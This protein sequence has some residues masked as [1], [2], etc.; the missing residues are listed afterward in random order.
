[1]GGS[2]SVDKRGAEDEAGDGGIMA[3]PGD[4]APGTEYRDPEAAV[5]GPAEAARREAAAAKA[6]EEDR[7]QQ[8]ERLVATIPPATSKRTERAFKRHDEDGD[9]I[10]NETGLLSILRSVG[11]TMNRMQVRELIAEDPYVE[12]NDAFTLEETLV[13]VARVNPEKKSSTTEL[14]EVF[15]RYDFDGDG[16]ISAR[17]L[18]NSYDESYTEDQIADLIALTDTDGDGKIGFEE[19]VRMITMRE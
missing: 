15:Q 18:R 11:H 17:D 5:D 13:L 19:F 16:Y 4:E 7:R 2:I 8:N 3:L 14:R 9:G 12:E 10:V 6:S 1:M